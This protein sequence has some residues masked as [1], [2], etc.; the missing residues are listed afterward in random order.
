VGLL[1]LPILIYV[2][3]GLLLLTKVGTGK[4]DGKVQFSTGGEVGH[5]VPVLSSRTSSSTKFWRAS[6]PFMIP[7]T[8]RSQGYESELQTIRWDCL[9]SC[10]TIQDIPSRPPWNFTRISLSWYFSKFKIASFFCL[11]PPGA[12][13]PPRPR[14][15]GPPPLGAPEP[16]PE[17][18]GCPYSS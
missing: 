12:L 9:Q 6:Y 2:L 18:R 8:N 16:R 10:Q 11:S 3:V 15:L 13:D 1:V 17:P 14:V 4:E 5:D 7:I